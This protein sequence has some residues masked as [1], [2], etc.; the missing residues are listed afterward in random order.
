MPWAAAAAGGA[1]IVGGL[2]SAGG[3]S[4]AADAQVKA[5]QAAIDFERQLQAQI[6]AQL[7]PFLDLGNSA[8]QPL[9]DLTGLTPGGPG[10]MDSYITRPFQPTQAQL[11]Q[12]PG[13]QFTRDQ[14]MKAVTNQFASQG[15]G[16]PNS[17]AFAKGLSQYVTGLASNTYQ[18]QFQNDLTSRST[19]YSMLTGLVGGGQNAAAQ[20]G[21]F[22]NS[23]GNNISN[24]ITGAGNA[25]AS[26]IVGASNAI[27][28]GISNAGALYG[29]LSR[30][31]APGQYGATNNGGGLG[32]FLSSLFGNNNSAAS[33]SPQGFSGFPTD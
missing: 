32:N 19:L 14:G 26:G 13:Y 20:L 3:A 7:K 15:L 27:G 18:Q 17:G 5:S 9:S 30:Q 11:E 10:V 1:S 8:I 23:I 29:L 21:G 25:Q 4:D 2:L 31:P 28:G 16:G 12:T 22:Q 33:S 24:N 6:T